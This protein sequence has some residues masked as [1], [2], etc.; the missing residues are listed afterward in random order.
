MKEKVVVKE[1]SEVVPLIQQEAICNC[2][3]DK[4]GTLSCN[5]SNCMKHRDLSL[6]PRAPNVQ[7]QITL[8]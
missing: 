7:S 8:G 1:K 2:G 4:I 3:S 6:I 5:N